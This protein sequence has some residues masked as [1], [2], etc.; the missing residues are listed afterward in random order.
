MRVREIVSASKIEAGCIISA[1]L[2]LA[3]P[4]RQQRETRAF[5][6]V[7]IQIALDCL[8]RA[9]RFVTTSCEGVSSASINLVHSRFPWTSR[10]AKTLDKIMASLSSS[11]ERLCPQPARP[12]STCDDTDRDQRVGLFSTM[13]PTVLR[14]LRSSTRSSFALRHRWQDVSLETFRARAIYRAHGHREP[15]RNPSLQIVG[16]FLTSN[17]KLPSLR[18]VPISQ[19][20]N[21]LKWQNWTTY[22]KAERV[23]INPG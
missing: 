2:A 22:L 7:N 21:S 11:V 4:M 8:N 18:S 9:A 12:A 5:V 15:H 23:H 16:V 17:S 3:R 20:G 1:P 19:G 6:N 13:S 10:P 14:R